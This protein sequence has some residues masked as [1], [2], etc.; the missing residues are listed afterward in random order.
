MYRIANAFNRADP[1]TA[2]TTLTGASLGSLMSSKSTPE[3]VV[4]ITPLTTPP[5]Q[6][7][8]CPREISCGG[9]HPVPTTAAARDGATQYPVDYP[10]E[11]PSHLRA[12]PPRTAEATSTAG[13]GLVAAPP[14]MS[15]L[16]HSPEREE[17][18]RVAAHGEGQRAWIQDMRRRGMDTCWAWVL[19]FSCF[20]YACLLGAR[21]LDSFFLSF[22][23]ASW[24]LRDVEDSGEGFLLLRGLPA[25]YTVPI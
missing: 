5:L 12:L 14:P 8:P 22:F 13:L 9:I 18:R 19:R 10:R 1:P 16:P 24:G 2:A 23:L 7:I 11:S 3:R 4:F 6:S 25:G 21:P 15:F 20:L 17:G